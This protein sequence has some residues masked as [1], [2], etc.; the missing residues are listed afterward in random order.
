MGNDKKT[1]IV[2]DNMQYFYEDMNQEQQTIVNHLEDLSR[3]ISS[4]QFN[5][6]QL[7]VG[8]QAFVQLLKEKL[9]V[10]EAT[11]VAAPETQPPVETAPAQ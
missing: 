6:D 7:S 4:S 9:T 5:L 1:P 11:P 8:R 3:K 10:P 2:I